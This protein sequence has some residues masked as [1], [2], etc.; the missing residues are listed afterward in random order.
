MRDP[1]SA[2]HPLVR[3]LLDG[4]VQDVSTHYHDFYIESVPRLCSFLL[5]CWKCQRGGTKPASSGH[6]TRADRD[7]VSAI[8]LGPVTRRGNDTILEN[9]QVESTRVFVSP[10]HKK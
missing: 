2:W 3:L 1:F 6:R 7:E 4:N 5:F 8:V 10:K 9:R